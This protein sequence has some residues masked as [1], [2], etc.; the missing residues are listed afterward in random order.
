MYYARERNQGNI[1]LIRVSK[2]EIEMHRAP[3][4]YVV[5]FVYVHVLNIYYVM[6]IN[7]PK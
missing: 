7:L 2:S 4:Y 5:E 1:L 3:T 6:I